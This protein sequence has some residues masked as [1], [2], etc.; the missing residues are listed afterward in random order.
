[1]PVIFMKEQIFLIQLIG[2]HW[3]HRVVEDVQTDSESKTKIIS[4]A[5]LPKYCN[6]YG[7][8]II[9]AFT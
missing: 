4:L 8:E 3:I 6:Q 5:L 1:M 2:A 9:A 7:S